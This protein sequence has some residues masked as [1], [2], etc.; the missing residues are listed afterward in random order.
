MWDLYGRGSG[1]VAIKSTVGRL[2]EQLEK[3]PFMLYLAQVQYVAW[4]KFH[5][6][7]NIHR[8]LRA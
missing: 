7:N 1:V 2:K 6:T 5:R 4:S 8:S 3:D